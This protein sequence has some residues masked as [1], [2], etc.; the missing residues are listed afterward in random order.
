M[1]PDLGQ[2]LRGRRGE[3]PFLRGLPRPR[4]VR[5]Q[6]QHWTRRARQTRAPPPKAW[7]RRG[8]A[9]SHPQGALWIG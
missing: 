5:G 4:A 7:Q 6:P 8:A 9:R 1:Q 2:R 3:V